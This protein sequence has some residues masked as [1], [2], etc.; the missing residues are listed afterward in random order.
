MHSRLS[1]AI[2]VNVCLFAFN[3]REVIAPIV[4]D[5][6]VFFISNTAVAGAIIGLLLVFYF[7][8]RILSE[9]YVSR[10]YNVNCKTY[11]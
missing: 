2:I 10:I 11:T 7:V 8:V 6:V 9:R 5:I 1:E 4:G 3:S